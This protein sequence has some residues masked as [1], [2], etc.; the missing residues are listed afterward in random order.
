MRKKRWIRRLAT[1]TLVLAFSLPL[2]AFGI[3]NLYLVSPKGRAKIASMASARLGLESS[4]AGATWSPWNGITLY[5][6]RIEQ[7]APLRAAVPSPL[8]LV[9][10][11]R[12]VPAWRM[13]LSKQL[14]IRSM[15]IVRPQL[16]IPIELLSQ[17]PSKPALPAAVASKL[18]ELA[19]LPTDKKPSPLPP[20]ETPLAAVDSVQQSHSKAEIL[21]PPIS[22][23]T[24]ATAPD[25]RIASIPDT[26]EPT[27]FV[28][29]QDARLRIVTTLTKKDLYRISAIDGVLPL[30]GKAADTMLTFHDIRSLGNVIAEEMEIPLRWHAPTLEFGIVEGKFFGIT[31]AIQGRLH[32][33]KGVPFQINAALPRQEKKQIHISE[34]ISADFASVVGQGRFQGFA[35]VPATW[36]GQLVT[37]VLDV[38]GK[39]LE[40]K[41]DFSHG[42]ALV[43]FRNGVLSCVDARLIGENLSVLG[44]ATLLTD[45]RG[46][47]NARVVAPPATLVAISKFTTPGSAAPNLSALSTPQRA[48]LD[49]QVFGR[50]GNFYFKSDPLAKPVPLQ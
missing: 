28:H 17:I 35:Q 42:E 47:A 39:Y 14:L 41:A 38:E 25:P 33:T 40:Q 22:A 5:G 6:L 27:F 10:S 29:L 8:L 32:V 13:I 46:A 36:E 3:S 31:C 45:G 23:E 26:S 19:V 20:V 2:L 30:G 7:P 18:P 1:S 34:K 15:D 43:L 11:I 24:Q 4:V 44:N 48:S 9:E 12:V 16:T 21:A 49:M 50:L 37:Q